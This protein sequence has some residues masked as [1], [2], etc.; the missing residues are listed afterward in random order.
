MIKLIDELTRT[1]Y[2]ITTSAFHWMAGGLYLYINNIRLYQYR[3]Y[4]SALHY[5]VF[6]QVILQYTTGLYLFRRYCSKQQGCPSTADTAVH[7]GIVLVQKI[8]QYTTELYQYRRYCSTLIGCTSTGDNAVHYR[9]L[10]VQKIQQYTTGFYQ[11]RRYSNHWVVPIREILQHTTGL[12]LYRCYWSTL[13]HCTSTE[14]YR[15]F[16]RKMRIM[17]KFL[18][19]KNWL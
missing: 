8:L 7:Y 17:L 2:L 6:L 12:Y 19:W 15:F 10:P 4:F 9:V 14:D 3:G 18:I 5:R 11:Y 16:S 13:Q 1:R